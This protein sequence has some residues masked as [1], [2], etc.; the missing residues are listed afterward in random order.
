MVT[1][2]DMATGEQLDCPTT[3][4]AVQGRQDAMAFSVEARLQPVTD[5]CV[6]TP[7]ARRMPADIAT[8][9]VA[10]FLSKQYR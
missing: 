10:Q 6:P 3:A 1:V 8:L 4:P 2:Y 9:P 7:A 5:E